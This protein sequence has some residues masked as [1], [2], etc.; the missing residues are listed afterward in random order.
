MMPDFELIPLNTHSLYFGGGK[1]Y[2]PSLV[3][4]LEIWVSGIKPGLAVK[5][6]NVI[7]VIVPPVHHSGLT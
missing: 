2:H 1:P 6:A 4:K 3:S 7:K 5:K